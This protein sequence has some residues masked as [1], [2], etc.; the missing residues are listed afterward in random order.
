MKESDVL[1]LI[2]ERMKITQLNE[3]QQQVVKIAAS[4]KTDI[5]LYSPTGSG[6]TLAF[7]IPLLKALKESKEEKLQAVVVVP[8]RE[9]ALQIYEVLRQI[10]V[11]HKI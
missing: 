7:S 10:A 1:R 8:S 4:V 11:G 6:K 5:V 9:L 3:M 2:E